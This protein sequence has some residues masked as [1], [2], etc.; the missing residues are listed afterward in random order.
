MAK[1]AQNKIFLFPLTLAVIFF[2]SIIIIFSPVGKKNIIKIN[3]TVIPTPIPDQIT[4][5]TYRNEK[6][7]FEISYPKDWKIETNTDGNILINR[8][9]NFESSGSILIDI[10][11]VEKITLPINVWLT[12]N[13]KTNKIDK[14]YISNGTNVT[15]IIDFSWYLERFIFVFSKNNKFVTISYED[16]GNDSTLAKDQIL[17]TFK[18]TQ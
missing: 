18:F 8:I 3:S 12:K 1:K 10:K 5:K 4:W 13:N 6:Y 16:D 11:N 15:K 9:D 17:S 2:A 7:N 14:E